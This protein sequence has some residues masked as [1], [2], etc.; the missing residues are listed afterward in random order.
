[1][2]KDKYWSGDIVVIR[3]NEIGIVTEKVGDS[4]RVTDGVRT[5]LLETTEF[6]SVELPP[7]P[8]YEWAQLSLKQMLDLHKEEK[9][10]SS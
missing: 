1:M 10:A 8:Y 3:D 7:M 5:R 9:N 4:Y 2:I 6:E